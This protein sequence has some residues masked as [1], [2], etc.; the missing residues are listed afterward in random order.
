MIAS[1]DPGIATGPSST[2]TS[3][4]RTAGAATACASCTAAGCA[5]C[6]AF[7]AGSWSFKSTPDASKG[8]TGRSQY[9]DG[10]SDKQEIMRTPW[11]QSYDFHR[12]WAWGSVRSKHVGIFREMQETCCFPRS[13]K[14]SNQHV[15]G[16]HALSISISTQGRGEF[17]VMCNKANLLY[18]S[19]QGMEK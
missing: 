7:A 4:A 14:H 13:G 8:Q 15:P 19:S 18:E 11:I 16:L 6:A 10:K 3:C 12:P 2:C 17:R 1:I 5:A 9:H